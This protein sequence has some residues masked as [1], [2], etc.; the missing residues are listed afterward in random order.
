MNHPAFKQCSPGRRASLGFDRNIFDI[1]LEFSRKPIGLGAVEG[2]IFFTSNEGLVGIAE[3]RSRFNKGLQDC[4]QIESRAADDF[5]HIGGRG[6]LLQR[7]RQILRTFVQFTE[8]PRVLDGDNGLPGE[9]AQQ[10]DLLVGE[11]ADLLSIGRDHAD[12]F[13]VLKHGDD[14]D[15]A[16]SS[17]LDKRNDC[18]VTLQVSRAG[19]EIR[20]V[21]RLPG[22]DHLTKVAFWMWSVRLRLGRIGVRKW[23]VVGGDSP[24][25]IHINKI[26]GAELG[27]ANSRRVLQQLLENRLQFAG[28]GA[29]DLKHFGR[30]RLLL[31]R[32]RQ[33]TRTR[34]HLVEQ[35]RI[36]DGDY[37]LVGKGGG[38]VDVSLVERLHSFAGN[39]QHTRHDA[40]AHQRYAQHAAYAGGALERPKSVFRV[41]LGIIN[42]H[43]CVR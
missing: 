29:D 3:P 2:P 39:E 32:F 22:A 14:G 30:R 16:N 42:E 24:N 10:L 13:S 18:G 8:Q 7:L 11:R 28:R 37:G 5:Q 26:H 25:D 1:L 27:P 19:T 4:R 21:D 36:L 6:L 34:L 23:H 41:A 43:G 9:I 15:R 17:Y 38:E 12:E 31:K 35:P 20:D 40:F 33:V